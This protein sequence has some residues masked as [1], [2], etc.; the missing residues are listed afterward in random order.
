MLARRSSSSAATL[1]L[2]K[3]R[4]GWPR[5]FKYIISSIISLARDRVRK[6]GGKRTVFLLAISP[7]YPILVLQ[8]KD[9]ADKRKSPWTGGD[10]AP[11]ALRIANH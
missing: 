11:G 1:R 5:A 2:F 10:A 8:F 7:K 3:K 4:I 6:K 9:V